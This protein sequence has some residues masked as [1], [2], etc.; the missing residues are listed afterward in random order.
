MTRPGP[1]GVALLLGIVG[2]ALLALAP[3]AP[4]A[5]KGEKYALLIGVGQ[6]R[7]T[8]LTNL[9]YA[10]ADVTELAR[11]LVRDCGYR[12]DHVVLMT[13]AEAA[14]NL[15]RAPEAEKIR[16][17]LA[18]FLRLCEEGDSLLIAIAGHGLQ[19]IG[20]DECYFCPA[21]ARLAD[22][23]TLIGVR[24]ELYAAL[25][26]CRAGFKLLLV[27]ACRNDPRTTVSRDA[28]PKV[29]L[30]SFTRPRELTPGGTAAFFSCSA[31]QKAYESPDLKHG[32]FF[33]FVIE[34][35]KGAAAGD[36]DQV[37]LPDL[38]GYVKRRVKAF[39]YEKFHQVQMPEIV[40]QARDLVPLARFAWRRELRRG[41][42]LMGQK[43]YP[44]A[45]DA[46]T[47]VLKGN[48]GLVAA[49]ARRGECYAWK[50]DYADAV[51]DYNEVLAAEPNNTVVRA[52][53]AWVY[54]R[55]RDYPKVI[56]DCT[57]TLRIDPSSA[58]AHRYRAWAYESGLKDFDRAI[59]DYGEVVRLE[60]K[61][62][63]AR[64][65]RADAYRKARDYDRGI[66]DCDAAVALEPDNAQAYFYRAEIYGY[67][68]QLQPALADY[69]R[70][71]RLDPTLAL[72]HAG[73]GWTLNGLGKYDDAIASCNR[74]LALDPKS[75]AAYCYRAD[76]Y[77]YK[78]QD[79]NDDR[80]L[81][82]A[83]I[84]DYNQAITLDDTF[85]MAFAGRGWTYNR[86]GQ[87]AQGVKDCTRAIELDP[88]Y[89]NAYRWRAQAYRNLGRNDLADS[90]DRKAD[91]LSGK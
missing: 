67:A 11:V 29:K 55:L 61:S 32:V 4:A 83:A 33:N 70:A 66:A 78:G 12:A 53:R 57:E 35:L 3:P 21:D 20:D 31:G 13:Q 37:T 30:D 25:Q 17:E 1:R 49:R 46:Y 72:A 54:F 27:D 62:V 74:A 22:P 87:A 51:R 69:D 89:A 58:A 6:Y 56:E 76:S 64:L 40:N 44:G 90:D 85:A 82:I 42:E 19:F 88:R 84:K 23:K 65:A 75:A 63:V 79:A 28:N 41:D 73:R 43:Q 14:T 68:Y 52:D 47:E 9:P 7:P 60:P 39:V 16:T 2:V 81:Y 91:M 36:D 48:P 8:E 80:N 77:G 10:A 45:I 24:K 59:A 15:D 34:G 18:T 71:I 50:G 38:E 5:A 26:N 86:V